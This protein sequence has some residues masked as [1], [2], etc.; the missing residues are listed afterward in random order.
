MNI[1]DRHLAFARAVVAL[2]R[3]HAMDGLK[4]EF[5]ETF[6]FNDQPADFNHENISM[7]WHSGRHGSESQIQLECRASAKIEEKAK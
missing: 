3:E 2:A 5:H 6:R 7:H 1:N 4:L